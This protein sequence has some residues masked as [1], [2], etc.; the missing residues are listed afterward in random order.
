MYLEVNTNSR[1]KAYEIKDNLDVFLKEKV[2]PKLESHFEALEKEYQFEIIRIEKLDLDLKFDHQFSNVELQDEIIKSID[3][4]V[5]KKIKQQATSDKGSD[6]FLSSEKSKLRTFLYFL[7][8][9][10]APWWDTKTTNFLHEIDQIE[11]IINVSGFENAIIENLKNHVSK[12]RLIKQF[13]DQVVRSVL[14]RMYTS[15]TYKINSEILFGDELITYLENGSVQNRERIW[16]AIVQYIYTKNDLEFY[17][18]LK[19][20]QLE[21]TEEL[22]NKKES[23]SKED[24][25][26]SKTI[27]IIGL[28]LNVL[29]EFNLEERSS[30]TDISQIKLIENDID[31]TP[32]QENIHK[33]QVQ[34]LE[35]DFLTKNLK[36]NSQDDQNIKTQTDNADHDEIDDLVE[37]SYYISNA[38]LILLHPYLKYFFEHCNLLDDKSKNIKNQELA[39]HL[40]HYVATQG[41]QQPEHLMIFEKFLCN[42]PIHKPI[43]RDVTLL[44]EYKNHA[45]NLLEATLQNWGA[46]KNASPDLLRNEFIQRPG[47]LILKGDNPKIIIERKTQDILLDRLPW[48]ISVIKLPW[49]DKLIFADW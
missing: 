5:R 45:E 36:E 24:T 40:L 4:E 37:E 47:K 9:G 39:T 6:V 26:L 1:D 13:P 12:Q 15:A 22:K 20:I 49:K 14:M 8:K 7:K 23:I 21:H 17:Q 2:F 18:I 42:I 28:E 32:D 29:E 25:W 19:N 31:Q 48:N 43:A 41:H 27:D 46:L 35:A 3:Q 33:E 44:E 34:E 30:D 11:E 16:S 10:T 38:G